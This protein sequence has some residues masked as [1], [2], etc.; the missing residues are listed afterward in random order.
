MRLFCELGGCWLFLYLF[1]HER[2][3]GWLDDYCGRGCVCIFWLLG[4]YC[5][6]FQKR[7]DFPKFTLIYKGIK[8]KA[9]INVGV[10]FICDKGWSHCLKN[11]DFLT[12]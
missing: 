8:K 10:P 5:K 6:C 4:Q 11:L 1:G 7:A 3:F 2:L 12:D 9:E